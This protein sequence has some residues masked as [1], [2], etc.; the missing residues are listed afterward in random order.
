MKAQK[1]V[2]P[3]VKLKPYRTFREIEQPASVFL[4]RLKNRDGAPPE[5]ALF[6]A[7]GGAWKLEATDKIGKYFA[8]ELEKTIT[9]VC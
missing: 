7:D 1:K 3:K 8:G 9:I 2:E 6:E 5:C 4:F